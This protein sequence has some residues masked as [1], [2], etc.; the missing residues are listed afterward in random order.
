MKKFNSELEVR[1]IGKNKFELVNDLSYE[2]KEYELIIK[3]GFVFDGASIPRILWTTLGCPFGE[4]YTAPACVHDAL[5]ST[6]VFERKECD[7][8]FHRAMR[9]KGVDDF[10]AKEMYLAVRAF[11]EDSYGNEEVLKYKDMVQI[12]IK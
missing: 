6:T 8:I 4:L 12:R 1:L 9:A 3:K 7:K 10:T 5:Y 11:G 2:E